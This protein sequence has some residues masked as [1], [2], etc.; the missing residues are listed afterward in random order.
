MFHWFGGH[1]WK[2]LFAII[3]VALVEGEPVDRTSSIRAAFKFLKENAPRGNFDLEQTEWLEVEIANS[4]SPL[5]ALSRATINH[6]LQQINTRAALATKQTAWPLFLGDLNPSY[7]RM[8]Q[9]VIRECRRHSVLMLGEPV[10][11]KTP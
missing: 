7:L 4:K 2:S 6:S 3:P 9:R 1:H 10:W 8:F 5:Q 11:A